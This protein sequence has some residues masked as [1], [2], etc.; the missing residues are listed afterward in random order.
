[1][2]INIF[3]DK[4]TLGRSAAAHASGSLRTLIS[5][6]E[7]VRLVA[8]TGASQFEFLDALTS[9]PGIDWQ[10]VELFHL[11]EYAGLPSTHPASFRKYILER[12]VQKTGI[13]N[14]HLLDGE[15][16]PYA[17]AKEV[18]EQIA[19]KPVDLIFAGIGENCHIAFNDPPA[20]FQ[21]KVPY[22]VVTLDEACRRQQVSEGWFAK[23][24]DVPKQAIS[25]SVHQMLQG[26]E[27]IV[28]APDT[29]KA[30]AVKATVEGEITPMAPAS[31]L[32]QHPNTTL[33]LDTKSAALLTKRVA[34]AN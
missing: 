22:L 17:M 25:M 2:K 3:E 12:I 23:L 26:K 27:I 9:T 24:G 8:A 34:G 4:S 16:D 10:R 13:T 29:R 6:Q 18:S 33:Y 14:H 19:S 28:I 32:R 21:T 30:N 15:R 20:D 5:S 11:D 7:Y 31:I 1:L